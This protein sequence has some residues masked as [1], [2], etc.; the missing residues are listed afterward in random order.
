MRDK[1]KREFPRDWRVEYDGTKTRVN[2]ISDFVRYA[3]SLHRSIEKSCQNCKITF[4]LVSKTLGE[5]AKLFDVYYDRFVGL[6]CDKTKLELQKKDGETAWNEFGRFNS[7]ALKKCLNREKFLFD[8]DGCLI[9]I[10]D[11]YYEQFS[12]IAKRIFMIEKFAESQ[13]KKVWRAELTPTDKLNL[14]QKYMIMVKAVYPESWRGELTPQEINFGERKRYQ[15]ASLWTDMDQRLFFFGV[16]ERNI[17]SVLVYKPEPEKIVCAFNGDA[18]SDEF[19]DGH[20]P[21]KAKCF[22]SK[23]NLIDSKKYVDGNHELYANANNV[24]L[25]EDLLYGG[26]NEYNEIVL[27]DPKV[28]GV[29]AP[30]KESIPFAK[31]VAKKMNVKM[32]G[33]IEEIDERFDKYSFQE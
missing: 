20:C 28:V 6:L 4:P 14:L 27:N 13:T 23:I 31:E 16:G 19:I 25:P 9:G 2:I 24:L 8:G 33:C 7:T 11:Q 32:I 30:N 22:Y 21:Y 3:Y 26:V 15:S 12:H 5:Y 10:K 17:A 29:I 18:F 1:I